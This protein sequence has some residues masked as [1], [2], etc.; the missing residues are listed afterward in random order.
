MSDPTIDPSAEAADALRTAVQDYG[1]R[2]LSNPTVLT[3]LFKDLLPTLP[4]EA[5]LLIQASEA[6]VP[7]MLA[8]HINQQM[9][10]DAAVQLAAATLSQRRALDPAACSWAAAQF[11]AAL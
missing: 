9:P 8:E 5:S 11:A 2:G 4:R 6:G 10:P 7:D 1:P 3:N